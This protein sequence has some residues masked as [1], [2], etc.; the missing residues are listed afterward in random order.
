MNTGDFL[1]KYQ[2]GFDEAFIPSSNFK[3][4]LDLVDPPA[5]IIHES[6]S[7]D[8]PSKKQKPKKIIKKK[9]A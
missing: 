8:S 4:Q 3:A 9:E 6:Q 7:F 1:D 2:N 5:K